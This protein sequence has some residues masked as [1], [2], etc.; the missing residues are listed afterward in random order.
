[1]RLATGHEALVARVSRGDGT[2][3]FGFSLRLDGTEARH[4]AEWHAGVREQRP[5][6][7]PV[8]GHPW[9]TAY[10]ANQSV[11]WSA[12]PGFARLRWL[13]SSD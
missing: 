6:I 2:A 13:T 9:E 3:G 4:M 12:E 11:D 10:L 8:L 5:V 1:M 7:E